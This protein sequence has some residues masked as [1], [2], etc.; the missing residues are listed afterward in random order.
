MR[1][2]PPEAERVPV[3]RVGKEPAIS[4]ILN[5]DKPQGWTS[6]DVVAKVRRLSGQKRVGHAGTLDPLATGVLLVCL[7]QATRVSEYL[8]RGRKVYRAAVHLG[9]STDT[10]DADGQ[11]TARTPEVNVTLSQLEEALSA[12]VGRIEQIPPMYSALKHRGTPLYKLARQG[13]T[14]E[15]KPRP[16][17]IYDV[18]LLDWS[19]PVLTIEIVCSPGTYLRSLAHD[20]GQRL[21]CGAHLSSLTRLASGHF[22]LDKAI[23][24]DALSEAFATG[25]WV[26]LI[27][28][29]DEALLDFETITFGSQAERQIRFGQQ[30]QG[31]MPSSSPSLC[32][33]YST[34]GKLIA[35][36]QYDAQTGLWQPK[37]V[38]RQDS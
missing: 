13:K 14:V 35:L 9:L 5:I 34:E 16:V 22:T 37:K 32:R 33:A 10:Y 8:M 24:L 19:S 11:V 38:F 20:L 3:N 12:F 17:E 1:G 30:V 26:E 31:P 2:T 21:G 36:L 25:R 23:R 18:K 6:H 29:L 7:G 4:G 28:P 15:R 27:H